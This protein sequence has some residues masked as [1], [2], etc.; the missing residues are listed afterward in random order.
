MAKIAQE[1]VHPDQL[2]VVVVGD[3]KRIQSEL[4]TIAPVTVVTEDS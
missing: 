3:A 2:V 4:E 1:R